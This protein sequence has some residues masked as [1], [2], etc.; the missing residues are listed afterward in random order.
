M[1]ATAML[2]AHPAGA[3]IPISNPLPFT[4]SGRL[5][6]NVLLVHSSVGKTR[7]TVYSL[8][9]TNH[10]YGK[11]VEW[12]DYGCAQVLQHW[13]AKVQAANAKAEPRTLDYIAMNRGAAKEGIINP[14]D[15]RKYRKLHPIRIQVGVKGSSSSIPV[16]AGV[17]GVLNRKAPIPSDANPAFT[18]GK[19][20][21]PS[22]PVADLMTDRYQREW[23]LQQDKKL[24]HERSLPKVKSNKPKPAKHR[25]TDTS[26]RIPF[27]NIAERDPKSLWKISKFQKVG[28]HLHTWRD[29]SEAALRF[30]ANPRPVF[31]VADDKWLGLPP[32]ELTRPIYMQKGYE[33]RQEEAAVPPAAELNKKAQERKEEGKSGEQGGCDTAAAGKSVRFNDVADKGTE[34]DK[35]SPSAEA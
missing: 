18:Y 20:T 33:K 2:S 16:T 30:E 31:R 27:V 7:P 15:L 5:T 11:K 32:R 12:D 8:P 35:H 19:P 3:S 21:R 14:K 22:T 9:T 26:D 29:E 13:H 4:S 17:G 10:V 34:K 1:P 24:A 23:Q 25:D 6:N 28:A